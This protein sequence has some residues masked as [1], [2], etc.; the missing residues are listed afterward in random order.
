MVVL[1]EIGVAKENIYMDKQLGKNFNRPQYQKL[2]STLKKGDLLYMS[3]TVTM[4]ENSLK[5]TILMAIQ[6]LLN[7]APKPEPQPNHPVEDEPVEF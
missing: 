4:G 7:V 1:Q 3:P 2:L 6:Q 5:D